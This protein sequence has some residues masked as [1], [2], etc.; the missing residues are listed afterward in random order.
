MS[1]SISANPGAF[2]LS[3]EKKVIVKMT[4]NNR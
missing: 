4:A 1:P 2:A 3:Q